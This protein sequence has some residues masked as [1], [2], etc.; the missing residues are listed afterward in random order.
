VLC[1]WLVRRRVRRASARGVVIAG[2]VAAVCAI[3]GHLASGLTFGDSNRVRAVVE[4]R[5]VLGRRLVR[6]YVDLSDRDGDGFAW[7]WGGG[8]C[9]DARADVHPGAVDEPGDGVDADCFDGDGSREVADFGDGAWGVRPAALDRP[10][11]LLITVDALR[12]DHLG[13]YGYGRPT[14]PRIDAFARSAVRFDAAYAQSSRSMRSIPSMMTGF[15][16]SQVAF[17]PEYLWPTLLDENVTV[18]ERLRARG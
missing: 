17:G 13:A 18:A 15:Y 11:F 16:P 10:N 8:D 12:P 14:S 5:S 6:V 2:F 1:A 7:A 3:G 4:Q 9:D